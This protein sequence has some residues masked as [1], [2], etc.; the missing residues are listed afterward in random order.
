MEVGES[1][2]TTGSTVSIDVLI[3]NDG[4]VKRHYLVVVVIRAPSGDIVYDSNDEDNTEK[5]SLPP[6]N[7]GGVTFHWDIRRSAVEGTY[8]VTASLVDWND[9][10]NVFDMKTGEEGAVFEIKHKPVLSLSPDSARVNFGEINFAEINPESTSERTFKVWNA[11]TGILEWK[12]TRLPQEWVELISP[13]FNKTIVGPGEIQIR[14]KRPLFSI[15]RGEEIRGTLTLESNGGIENVSLYVFSIET[16]SN[17]IITQFRVLGSPYTDHRPGDQVEFRLRVRNIGDVGVEYRV[18]I[19]IRGPA[20]SVIYDTNSDDADLKI[21]LEPEDDPDAT[22]EAHFMNWTIPLS[23][24][25]GT[26]EVTAQLRNWNDFDSLYFDTSKDTA[27]DPKK[28][29][30]EVKGNPSTLTIS[31]SSRE[32]GTVVQGDTLDLSFDVTSSDPR[33]L[34]W[35]VAGWPEWVELVSPTSSVSGSGQIH[36]KLKDSVPAGDQS[37]VIEVVSNFGVGAIS[38]SVSILEA[39]EKATPTLV[40][41]TSVPQTTD[42]GTLVPPTST[43]T[44]STPQPTIAPALPS[45]TPVPQRADTATPVSPTSTRT[46]FSATAAPLPKSR[47]TSASASATPVTQSIAVSP[48]LPAS[49]MPAEAAKTPAGSAPIGVP[50]PTGGGCSSGLGRTSGISGLA[51]IL[52]LFI[53]LAVISAYRRW[54]KSPTGP[55]PSNGKSKATQ[56]NA[57]R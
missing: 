27:E 33:K 26:Y 11:G 7:P 31:P 13:T 54:S 45:A 57:R 24:V 4:D 47:A 35:E 37:G 5:V 29:S 50:I 21:F 53:P 23:A 38:L 1:S 55:T 8:T 14:V 12:V 20:G 28:Y 40:P 36:V 6:G 49:K 43:P 46:P 15:A 9:F 22:D 25:D 48:S 52:F 19:F 42:I 17:G 3:K 2:Y 32:L 16:N 39:E 44:A 34:E 51:N 56:Q 41:A 18:V 10:T 30:F